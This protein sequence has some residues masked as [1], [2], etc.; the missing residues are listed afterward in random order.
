[1]YESIDVLCNGSLLK[2]QRQLMVNCKTIKRLTCLIESMED[3]RARNN[4][5]YCYRSNIV[6]FT[7]LFFA[8]LVKVRVLSKQG[9]D[10][11]QDRKGRNL[12]CSGLILLG[13][14]LDKT[15]YKSLRKS[16][17][18]TMLHIRLHE[19]SKAISRW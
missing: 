11:R 4:G 16:C 18:G 8:D 2:G 19:R 5:K 17:R 6:I 12:L 9:D 10:Q 7:W 15:D 3:F 14:Y 13:E 1:M